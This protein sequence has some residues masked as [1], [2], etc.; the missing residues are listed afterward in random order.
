VLVA[1]GLVRASAKLRWRRWLAMLPPLAALLV[2][3][4][5][6]APAFAIELAPAPPWH[7]SLVGRIRSPRA[8]PTILWREQLASPFAEAPVLRWT[9]AG[10]PAGTRYTLYALDEHGRVWLATHEWSHGAIIVQGGELAV[11][12][13]A[14]SM[15]PKDVPL[16]F[17]LRRVP[18]TASD[19][20]ATLPVSAPLP[21][22]L[23]AH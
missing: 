11:P 18:A 17:V 10:A 14:M 23:A 19:V 6:F 5:W 2:F 22:R 8:S 1:A 3:A 13:V 16:T 7:R 4:L 12:D 9:D 20:P 21:F 15:L